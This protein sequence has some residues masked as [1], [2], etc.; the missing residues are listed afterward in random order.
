M[1]RTK[2]PIIPVEIVEPSEAYRPGTSP[3]LY[4]KKMA[5]RIIMLARLGATQREMA[6]A[7]GVSA[8]TLEGWLHDRKDIRDAYDKGKFIHD[9]GV[10]DSLLKRALGFEYPETKTV[11]GVDSIGRSYEHTTTSTKVVLADP[12]SMIF[13]LK[14]RDPGRWADVQRHQINSS[15]DVNINNTLKLDSLTDQQ[16][17]MVQAIALKQLSGTNGLKK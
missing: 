9:H 1:K 14:N 11:V 8:K 10:Q 15:V 4:N 13:W 7:I 5:N 17:E 12:T 6:I 16:R 3:K 2:P